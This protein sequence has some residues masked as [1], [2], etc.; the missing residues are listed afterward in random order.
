MEIWLQ[1]TLAGLGALITILT[2]WD[3]IESR[4][5][6]TKEPSEELKERVVV[7][8][9]KFDFDIKAT[10]VEYESRFKRDLERINEIEKSNK[11]TQKALVELMRH[12]VD[13][14]N[15][16]RLKKVADELNEYIYDKL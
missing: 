1:Y 4:I 3:K 5:K 7:L 11:L 6:K 8:E 16:E 12:E 10:F 13:G 15:T 9:K 14:N 2:V